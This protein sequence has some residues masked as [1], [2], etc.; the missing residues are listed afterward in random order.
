MKNSCNI[1]N[2]AMVKLVL[3]ITLCKAPPAPLISEINERFILF[4]SIL[5]FH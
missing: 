5:N 4:R 1:S 3:P 2:P